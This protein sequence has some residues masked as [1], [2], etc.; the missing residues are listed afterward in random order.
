MCLRCIEPA[1]S[2]SGLTGQ[3]RKNEEML[4][5]LCY[6]LVSQKFPKIRGKELIQLPLSFSLCLPTPAPPN[7]LMTEIKSI[8]SHHTVLKISTPL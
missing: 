8:D 7:G 4:L 3:S 2:F 1:E 6:I 5:S